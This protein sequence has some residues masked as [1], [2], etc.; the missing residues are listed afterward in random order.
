MPRIAVDVMGGD[1]VP[2]VPVAG[3]I[4]ALSNH[5][6]LDLILVGPCDRIETGR[7]GSSQ[8]ALPAS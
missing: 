5:S 1:R 3:A 8:L 4:Q 2:Q 7:R 6:D